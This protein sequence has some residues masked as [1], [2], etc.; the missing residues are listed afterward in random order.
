MQYCP[1]PFLLIAGS[2]EFPSFQEG[3]RVAAGCSFLRRPN[4]KQAKCPYLTQSPPRL[5]LTAKYQSGAALRLPHALQRAKPLLCISCKL[6][7]IRGY[8]RVAAGC[9]FCDRP[10]VAA[11][12]IKTIQ[13]PTLF[14]SAYHLPRSPPR[15]ASP[16]TPSRGKGLLLIF[17]R[18]P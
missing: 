16:A 1:A 7:V 5:R 17:L 12:C 18:L 15:Q 2:T 10:T 14:F 6:S 8:R 13:Y 11:F 4:E 9:S 3:C